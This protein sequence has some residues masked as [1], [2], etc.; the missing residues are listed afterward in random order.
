MRGFQ[1]GGFRI[2]PAS[3]RRDIAVMP[4]LRKLQFLPE[5]ILLFAQLG[6]LAA[7]R[8]RFLI[9][10]VFQLLL[11]FFKCVKSGVEFRIASGDL[12]PN[13]VLFLF[14]LFDFLF[15]LLVGRGKAIFKLL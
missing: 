4:D 15:Q 9:Q 12:P 13:F 8:L 5:L 2:D 1:R 6:N 10:P 11:L 3:D 14:K 7:K